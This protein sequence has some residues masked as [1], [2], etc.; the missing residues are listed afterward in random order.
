MTFGTA[1]LWILF[2][3][4]CLTVANSIFDIKIPSGSKRLK[5][6]R[7]GFSHLRNHKFKHTFPDCNDPILDS[8]VETETITP[9]LLY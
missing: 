9:F 6:L 5:R 3:L 8:G 7:K 1:N 2:L 4:L